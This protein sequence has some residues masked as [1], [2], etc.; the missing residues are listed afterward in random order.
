MLKPGTRLSERDRLRIWK[1]VNERHMTLKA[2]AR[3]VGCHINTV[4]K[5]SR[6]RN[7]K[8]PGAMKDRPSP[9]RPK[10][11]TAATRSGWTRSRL[12]TIELVRAYKEKHADEGLTVSRSTVCRARAG[13][14]KPLTYKKVRV[15][16]YLSE[17]VETYELKAPQLCHYATT[18]PA[19]RAA[20]TV[21]PCA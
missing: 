1:D 17:S 13:G 11:T 6:V 4:K 8:A 9:G 14:T 21:M 10:K 20:G 2:V 15:S 19:H 12:P 16:E 18:L 5:W 3:L 7:A